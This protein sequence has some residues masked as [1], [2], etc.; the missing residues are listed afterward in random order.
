MFVVTVDSIDD[1]IREAYMN[2]TRSPLNEF[3]MIIR[4]YLDNLPG[5]INVSRNYRRWV[6][7]D[8]SG[9]IRHIMVFTDYNLYIDRYKLVAIDDPEEALLNDIRIGYSISNS[10][11]HLSIIIDGFRYIVLLNNT[12]EVIRDWRVSR[13]RVIGFISRIL[14]IDLEV[15]DRDLK[16]YY[17]L[18]NDTI[19]P[20]YF[21]RY[22][23]KVDPGSDC[24]D[25][26]T[27]VLVFADTG[28]TYVH[29]FLGTCWS[30]NINGSSSI[31]KYL[32]PIETDPR[33]H[34]YHTL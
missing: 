29:S 13:D 5:F 20:I 24:S 31:K 12:R 16:Q 7:R 23:G 33:K 9:N 4:Q 21:F 1:V 32:I 3:D 8:S 28:G 22:I 27:D 34:F 11:N 6:Y 2:F 25:N 17:G 26:L 10:T 30:Q 15:V 14:S 19:R 18:L